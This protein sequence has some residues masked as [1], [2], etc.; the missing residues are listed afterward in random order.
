MGPIWQCCH[1]FCLTCSWCCKTFWRKSRFPQN[2]EIEKSLF[3]CLNLHFNVKNAIVRQIYTLKLFI[4]VKMDYY[5]C[6]SL[7]GILH[8]TEFLQKTFYN[9]NSCTDAVSEVG[10][11]FLQIGETRSVL[12][13]VNVKSKLEEGVTCLKKLCFGEPWSSG[14]RRRLVFQ[15]LWVQI[16]AQYTG[17]T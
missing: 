7:G 6:F 13:K 1:K 9:I 4:A 8:I 2:K 11:E 12:H 16:L 17:W 10:N 3:W 15:R 5:C 14:Y